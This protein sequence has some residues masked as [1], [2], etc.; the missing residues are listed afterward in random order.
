MRCLIAAAATFV[1][2]SATPSFAVC[3][4]PPTTPGSEDRAASHLLCLQQELSTT[5]NALAEQARINADRQRLN[6]LQR[7]QRNRIGLDP[8]W[9]PAFP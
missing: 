4:T 9:G 7:A 8:A 5:A 2:L 6:D 3:P 1:A